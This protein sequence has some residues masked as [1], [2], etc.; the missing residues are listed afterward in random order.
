MALLLID[1]QGRRQSLS[2]TLDGE[3]APFNLLRRR[4]RGADAGARFPVMALTSPQPISTGALIPENAI[5]PA[6]QTGQF[7]EFLGSDIDSVQGTVR[8][9]ISAFPASPRVARRAGR[10]LGQQRST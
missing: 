5:L 6:D 3:T 9:T 4:L 2:A 7:W 10:R 8:A 1:P